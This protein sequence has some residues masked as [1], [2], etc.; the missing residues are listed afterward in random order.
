MLITLRLIL[1]SILSIGCIVGISTLA[2]DTAMVKI[3][4]QLEK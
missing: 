3:D 1:I 4:L 2:A